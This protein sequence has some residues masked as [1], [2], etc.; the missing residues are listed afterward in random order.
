MG[1]RSQGH[2]SGSNH[3]L[4]LVHSS[5]CRRESCSANNFTEH[6]RAL[7]FTVSM[8]MELNYIKCLDSYIT[9][10]VSQQLPHRLIPNAIGLLPYSM[11]S[12]VDIY[13]QGHLITSI[14]Q[15][16]CNLPPSSLLRL[17]TNSLPATSYGSHGSGHQ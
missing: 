5:R 9:R 4:S 15:S 12:C 6:K 10:N 1:L 11:L 2:A 7:L 3:D 13:H 17:Q 14:L 8:A 16:L